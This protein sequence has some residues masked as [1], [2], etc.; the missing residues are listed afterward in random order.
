MYVQVPGTKF[1]WQVVKTKP[2]DMNKQKKKF[3][4]GGL[5]PSVPWSYTEEKEEKDRIC[6]KN[7]VKLRGF[8]S[9]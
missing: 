8:Y 1:A 3:N 5:E 9:C 7:S 6:N 2:V 4:H